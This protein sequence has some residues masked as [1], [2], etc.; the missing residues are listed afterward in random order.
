MIKIIDERGTGKT[1]KLM[2]AAKENDGILVCMH[3][4]RMRE[5]AFAYGI[6]GLN[7][8]SYHD[9]D[10]SDYDTDKKCYID[11]LEMF[12]KWKFITHNID[13]YSFTIGD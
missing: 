2:L 4:E 6:T 1:R 13:G 8:I 3:P 11:E 12:I 10:I 7:I 9:F 5:K